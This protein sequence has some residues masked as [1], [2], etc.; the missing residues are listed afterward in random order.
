MRIST[1]LN[2]FA[3]ALV[4]GLLALALVAWSTI[5]TIRVGG[6]HY[7]AIIAGKDLTADMLPPPLYII[8]AYLTVR[9]AADGVITA[10]EAGAKLSR[11][12][13][14][15]DQRLAVWRASDYDPKVKAI[16]LGA[17]HQAAA[18]FWTLSQQQLMPAIAAANQ[19]EV[20]RLLPELTA[21]YQR[22]RQAVD[23][24]VP[25][26]AADNARTEAVAGRD[27]ARSVGLMSGLGLVMGAI[28][29]AGVWALRRQV[30]APVLRIAGYMRRLAT[31]DYEEAPPFAGRRDE[32]GSMAESVAVF[33]ESALERRTLREQA[34]EARRLG[35]ADRERSA[36]EQA[37]AEREQ[38]QVVAALA[39][40]LK[41]LSA[42]DLAVRIE[43]PVAERFQTLRTD[44]NA[45]AASLAEVVAAVGQVAQSVRTASQEISG[46]ADDLSRRT[47][48]QAASLEETAAALEEITATISRTAHGAEAANRLSADARAQGDASGEVVHAAIEAMAR[49]ETSSGQIGRIIG[50]IDEI[51]FQT[52][53]L[54]LNAGVEAARAG[55]AGRGF[56]VVATEVRALA[57]RSADAA[58]E[59]KDLIQ[60]SSDEVA[61]GV[62]LVRRAGEALDAIVGK[63]SSIHD[64]LGEIA[65]STNEQSQGLGQ[66]NTAVAHMD[67]VTQQNAAM[68]EQ[69]SAAARSLQDETAE[70]GRRLQRFSTGVRAAA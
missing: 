37:R 51:A 3:A 67:Q 20:Q 52:N 53:L 65:G 45:A 57:Q 56:A 14:E 58:K 40:A 26:I 48:Q 31:G 38:Q 36:A 60:A 19:A 34:E 33:R 22:H 8:E 43:T 4:G 62:A 59:I 50:V 39:E 17:S 55:E 63:V 6:R 47:E 11:L 18:Q 9:E 66:V 2:L 29:G 25:M 61:G 28:I 15:Y 7:D 35:E 32:I 1:A 13:S 5:D 41:R 10:D 42:G 70:L 64:Q 44:F 12:R 69:T 46:A 27:Q 54:A 49:I 30:L 24:M 68:V 21:A 16:L 23:L